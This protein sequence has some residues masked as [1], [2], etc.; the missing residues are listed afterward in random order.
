MRTILQVDT[1][2]CGPACLATV[3]S[4]WS[5]FEPLYR[6]R[7]LAGTSQNGTSMGGLVRAA[8]ALNLDAKAYEAE[9]DDL[10]GLGLPLILHWEHN[11]Y[12]VL[13]ELTDKHAVLLDPASGRRR[14]PLSEV[15]EKWTGNVLWLHPQPAFERGNF[16]GKRG[17]SGLLAHLTHFR[18]SQSILTEVAA[19]TAVLALL[20][21]VSPMLS[22]VLF[23]RVLTFRESQLLPYLLIGILL[24][25]VF[26][27]LFG[28]IRSYLSSHLAMGLNY[29]MQLGYL[30]HLL[31]LPLRIHETRLVGDLLQRA[32]DLSNVRGVITS[33]MIEVPV[34]VLTLILSISVLFFYNLSLALV[35]STG[36]IL[37]IA[38]MFILSPRLRANSRKVLKKSGELNS[39]M[40]G[41]LEGISAIKAF[42]AEG[43]AVM[44]G[45]NQISGLIDQSWRGFMLNNNG[46]IV[47]GLLGSLASLLTL[48]FG[49][50][51]V[52]AG[53]LSVGQLVATYGLTGNALG[54]LSTL[55]GSIQAVQQG[56]VSSDRLAE[57]LELPTEDAQGRSETLPPLQS[58]LEVR[59]LSFG[60]QPGRPV[61][62]DVSL[63]LPRGSY[64]VL[65]GPNG[66]GKTTL[67]NLLTAMLE[68]SAGQMLWDG[69][70]LSDYA[71]A[72]VRGRVAYQR[73]EVP[74]FYASMLEN[75]TL[76][77]EIDERRVA[78]IIQ[79]LQMEDIVRR[80]PEQLST[81]LGGDSPHRLSSGERQLVGL[82]RALLSDADLLILDEPT[83]T[84]DMDREARVVQVLN[85]LKG[86]KTLL[87]VTHRSPLVEPADQVL[88]I[89]NGML[90]PY[91]P[92]QGLPPIEQVYA[93]DQ[94]VQAPRTEIQPQELV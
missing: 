65:L 64:T 34:A 59:E 93:H 85:S 67:C 45:R 20:G 26:Q 9:L 73:Q 53:H 61:L 77:R 52:L 69:A 3:L 76:G 11:H 71:T 17:M 31:H 8:A 49:A 38:Y 42:S 68:P 40:I 36:L 78:A 29:R 88:E 2:D 74:L 14:V 86:H 33:V 44:K 35:A 54:A 25:A 48:W 83:A 27:T 47:F 24:F 15:K 46:G 1:T 58:A 70:P 66:S 82:A 56:I 79:M 18:G 60:Y 19:G 57:I 5:R 10:S 43:W 55:I 91:Q 90:A 32:E 89:R 80:L 72:A 51:Q 12:V 23:D 30:H 81:V 84:L 4:H 21:L 92:P 50:T 22:Q 37:D 6:L 28:T 13:A 63:T 7:E 94:S 87:V 62:K 39:F 41:N 75:L 16:V